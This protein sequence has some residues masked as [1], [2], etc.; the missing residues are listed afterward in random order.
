MN[1]A[2]LPDWPAAMPLQMASKYCGLSPTAFKELCPVKPIA[3]RSTAH[4]HRWPRVRLDE[5]LMENDPNVN[6][7]AGRN[8]PKLRL[9]KEDDIDL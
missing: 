9:V 2:A 4:S 8:G 7:S 5:W 6:P 3:F 1:S